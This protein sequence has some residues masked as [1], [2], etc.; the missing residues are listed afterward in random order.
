MVIP[1]KGDGKAGSKARSEVRGQIAEVE[2][3][4]SAP[5]AKLANGVVVIGF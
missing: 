4:W 1:G 5:F 2:N 3:I